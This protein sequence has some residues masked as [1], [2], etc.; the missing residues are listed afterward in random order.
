MA[1]EYKPLRLTQTKNPGNIVDTNIYHVLC[2][3]GR[4]SYAVSGEKKA[5]HGF[6]E[7][8]HDTDVSEPCIVFHH[9]P[10]RTTVKVFEGFD[11]WVS[12]NYVETPDLFYND[13]F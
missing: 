3:K 5:R 10:S 9:L 8:W 7:V 12:E 4:A 6:V 13:D 1:G 2:E 11:E